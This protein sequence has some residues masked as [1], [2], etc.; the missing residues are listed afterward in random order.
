M[1]NQFLNRNYAE[2]ERSSKICVL[3]ICFTK[4]PEIEIIPNVQSLDGLSDLLFH[5]L[6]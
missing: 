1:K 5:K 6:F 4:I 3:G 2:D